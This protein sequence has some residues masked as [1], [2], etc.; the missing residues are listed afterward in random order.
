MTEQRW[1]P[2]ES[3]NINLKTGTSKG[4]ISYSKVPHIDY[5]N[6]YL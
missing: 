3:I 6:D 2:R 4:V 5:F 1:H